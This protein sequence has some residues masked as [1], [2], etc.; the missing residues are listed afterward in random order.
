ML[1]KAI[2][3]SLLLAF[4]FAFLSTNLIF[5]QSEESKKNSGR[6]AGGWTAQSDPAE[7]WDNST[8]FGNLSVTIW[9]VHDESV[10][11]A[12]D[13]SKAPS[14]GK[15]I[16]EKSHE[17][18]RFMVLKEMDIKPGETKWED[19]EK[20][21]GY[22]TYRIKFASKKGK[23][24][25]MGTTDIFVP[26]PD[27]ASL[28][29]DYDPTNSVIN[30]G[31]EEMDKGSVRMQITDAQGRIVRHRHLRHKADGSFT[32]TLD[33]PELPA[34]EYVAEVFVNGERKRKTINVY[35]ELQASDQPEAGQND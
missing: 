17:S 16:I 28:H 2:S 31:V 13:E 21:P 34:G 30:F 23:V 12:W 8:N 22:T 9:N 27:V 32:E 19:P 1:K 35:H 3:P 7:F 29:V 33:V 11:L 25:H 15:I 26:K 5:A 20:E 24:T 4:L 6:F 18:G 14:N 10:E